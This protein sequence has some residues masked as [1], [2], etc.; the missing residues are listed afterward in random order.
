MTFGAE[1]LVAELDEIGYAAEQRDLNGGVS[2]VVIA[3]YEIEAGRFAGRKIDLAL[4]ATPDF[5]RS[6]HSSIHVRAQ[7]QLLEKTDT[8]AN[9]RNI[10]DSPLGAEWRY[11]SNNFGWSGNEERSARRLMSQINTIFERA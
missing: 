10:V 2:F 1:R 8:L 4:Q 5:P 9:I 11:W 3:D 6:V 7:P